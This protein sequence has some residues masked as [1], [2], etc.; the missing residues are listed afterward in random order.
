MS[1]KAKVYQ[2]HGT[3]VMEDVLPDGYTVI[4]TFHP[5]GTVTPWDYHGMRHQREY[6]RVLRAAG[7]EAIALTTSRRILHPHG[8]GPG[9]RVRFGDDMTPGTYR[10]AVPSE[11]ALLATLALEN[12]RA[13]ILNWL[14]N[15]GQIPA[16]CLD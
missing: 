3:R 9:G 15:G 6:I 1:L 4:D 11:V 2:E 7:I 13:D 16:A 14:N 12:H 10:L 5:C 8:T